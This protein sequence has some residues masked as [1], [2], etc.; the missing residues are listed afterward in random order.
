MTQTPKD[1]FLVTVSQQFLGGAPPDVRGGEASGAL[2][3]GGINGVEHPGLDQFE[4]LLLG[5]LQVLGELFGAHH[6]G[7]RAL[8][9]I[10]AGLH[11]L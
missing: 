5:D 1:A 8:E 10:T 3:S 7:H 4:E 11:K 9:G 2:L 6:A